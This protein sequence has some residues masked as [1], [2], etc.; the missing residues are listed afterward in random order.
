[1]ILSVLY[2][3][4]AGHQSPASS[5][6]DSTVKK[7]KHLCNLLVSEAHIDFP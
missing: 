7:L 4:T 1:M 5:M 3:F 2:G 6:F